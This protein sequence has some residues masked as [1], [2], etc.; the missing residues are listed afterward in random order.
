MYIEGD[1]FD[2]GS[3][4]KDID[5]LL[6]LS[7]NKEKERYEIVRG[8]H[9]V[10]SIKPGELDARI[11]TKLRQNDLAR[12]RL[13]DYIYELEKAEDEREKQLARE[14]S[15]KIESITLDNYDRVVGI[16]HFSLGG[17]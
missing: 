11:L 3:R 10:M 15:N 17:I 2:I 9:F 8:K 14:L 16:P 13:Q 4:V 6:S 7:L 1:I 12:R 5:P